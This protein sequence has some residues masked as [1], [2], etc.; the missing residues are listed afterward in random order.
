[1]Q[2]IRIPCFKS[3]RHAL[4]DTPGLIVHHRI[5]HTMFPAAM[6]ATLQPAPMV[7]TEFCVRAD[8]SLLVQLPPLEG[9][10]EPITLARIDITGNAAAQV[11]A[12]MLLYSTKV[13]S[14]VK[15]LE[16]SGRVAF[17]RA[18]RLLGVQAT[19]GSDDRVVWVCTGCA[20][21]DGGADRGCS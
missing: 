16:F 7:C 3:W 12:A 6:Q 8:H 15:R 14:N 18:P 4:F 17:V 2:A 11:N 20:V 9:T 13:S 10:D 5:A 21:C 19:T 1:M